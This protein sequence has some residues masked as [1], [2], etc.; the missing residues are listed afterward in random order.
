MSPRRD[1]TQNSSVQ[2]SNNISFNKSILSAVLAIITIVGVIIGAS[3]AFGSAR[4]RIDI[5]AKNI[6][7]LESE[8]EKLDQRHNKLLNLLHKLDTNQQ[9]IMHHLGVEKSR[10]YQG[11]GSMNRSSA[12]TH[13]NVGSRVP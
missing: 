8:H 4:D 1:A 13:S 9:V 6:N 7:R 12:V 10:W 5:N 11:G 2:N 3:M